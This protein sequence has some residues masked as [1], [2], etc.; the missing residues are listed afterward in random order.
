MKKEKEKKDYISDCTST[1]NSHREFV[2]K[3]RVTAG[4][5]HTLGKE[6]GKCTHQWMTNDEKYKV[7]KPFQCLC[8]LG[9]WL[10]L[11]AAST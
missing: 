5:V 2:K 3:K 8:P 7:H 6:L 1:L 11:G 4:E 9:R 10:I